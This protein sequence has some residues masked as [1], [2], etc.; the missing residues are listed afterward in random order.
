MAVAARRGRP[1]RSAQ[2]GPAAHH[3]LRLPDLVH[4]FLFHGKHSQHCRRETNLWV[5]TVEARICVL[6][7]TNTVETYLF[8][9]QICRVPIACR[10]KWRLRLQPRSA[11]TPCLSSW[12]FRS[13]M[14]SPLKYTPPVNFPYFLDCKMPWMVSLLNNFSAVE[15]ETLR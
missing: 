12:S 6:K 2:A 3:A 8:I 13:T 14:Y 1:P 5:L 15:E 4:A 9:Q 11:K 10:V 7:A